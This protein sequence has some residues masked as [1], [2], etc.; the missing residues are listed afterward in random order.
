LCSFYPEEKRGL[1]LKNP[2]LIGK[3]IFLRSLEVEDVK[4]F[5]HWLNDQEVTKYT[6]HG[7]FPV[8]REG[9]E[10]WLSD[11]R[12]SKNT[13][14][15]AIIDKKTDTHIGNCAI[16]K[17]NWIYRHAEFAIIIGEKKFWGKGIGTE[18]A[19][20]LINHAFRNLNLNKVWLGV[21]TENKDAVRSFEKAGFVREGILRQEIYRKGRYCDVIR[22][23]ILK[24]EL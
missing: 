6:S 17:I 10:K 7:I 11:T 23:S 15:L 9:E 12:K 14:V 21:N 13:I 5:Y 19:K 4:G 1:E 3:K 22:M 20:L 16:Q 18:V 8:T 2:L 24:Q